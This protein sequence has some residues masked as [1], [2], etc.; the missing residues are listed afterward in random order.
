[1]NRRVVYPEL[2]TAA[3]G[4]TMLQELDVSAF[5]DALSDLGRTR[6]FLLRFADKCWH[7]AALAAKSGAPRRRQKTAPS[8]DL[9]AR[10]ESDCIAAHESGH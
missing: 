4:G 6:A 5:T 3:V 9:V 7:E 8:L 1:M 2:S 10:I